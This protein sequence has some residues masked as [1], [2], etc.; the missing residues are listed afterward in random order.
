MKTISINL[1]IPALLAVVVVAESL[2]N[3]AVRIALK[4]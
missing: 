4:R 2:S 3:A 1:N